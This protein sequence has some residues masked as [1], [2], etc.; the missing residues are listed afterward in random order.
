MLRASI[1]KR[2]RSQ[3]RDDRGA[4]PFSLFFYA[5]RRDAVNGDS[6]DKILCEYGYL[7]ILILSVF[8]F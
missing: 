3:R 7:K 6:G 1:E 8:S 5:E 4:F 2:E